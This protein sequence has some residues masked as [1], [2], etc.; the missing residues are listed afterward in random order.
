MDPQYF[1]TRLGIREAED[2]QRG[3]QMRTRDM[4]E[5]TRSIVA[6]VHKVLTGKDVNWRFP[7]DN[8]TD[9]EAVTELSIDEARDMARKMEKLM[10]KHIEKLYGKQ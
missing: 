6:V 7:W 3:M 5:C 1:F 2:Y 4:Y 9:G 8:Q 10:A